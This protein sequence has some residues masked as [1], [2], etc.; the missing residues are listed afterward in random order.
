MMKDF[1]E[2]LKKIASVVTTVA[3]S[4]YFLISHTLSGG[5]VGNT[6]KV[7]AL[8]LAVVMAIGAFGGWIVSQRD[9][10]KVKKK[11]LEKLG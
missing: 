10:N 8:V 7:V 11:D 5:E 3:I 1:L 2:Y 9:E 6:T 4:L